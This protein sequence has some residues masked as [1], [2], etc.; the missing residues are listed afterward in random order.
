MYVRINVMVIIEITV[1]L[2]KQNFY[3]QKRHNICK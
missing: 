2:K 1:L 3:V